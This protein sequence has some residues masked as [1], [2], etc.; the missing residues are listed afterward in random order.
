MS[1]TG[2]NKPRVL[3]VVALYLSTFLSGSWAM[4]I[5]IIPVLARNFDVSAG[6]AAQIITA[7]A[8]G[9]MAGTAVGGVLL[10]R[11]GTRVGLVGSSVVAMIASFAAVWSPWF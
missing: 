8:F 7:F 11:K 3:S 5:P 4:I 9:K 2:D 10:D 1:S 6:G